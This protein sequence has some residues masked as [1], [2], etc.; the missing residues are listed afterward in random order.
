MTRRW[1][2]LLCG[3][4]TAGAGEMPPK[5]SNYHEALKKR[6][7]SATLFERFREAW[8]E[9]MPAEELEKE[10]LSRAEAGEAGAW[11]VLG[12]ARLAAANE[13]GALEAFGKARAAAP[14]AWLSLEIGRLKLAA[15]D[16]EGAEKEALAVPA[17]DKL[18]PDALKLAGLACLRGGRIEE[19]Q[20]HWEQAVAAAPGDKSLLEDLTELTRREGRLDLALEYGGKWRE[21]A[22]DAYARALATLVLAELLEASQRHDDALTELGA[23]LEVS[24]DGSWLE[25]EALSRVERAFRQRGDM[26]R[27]AAW[28]GE[29]ADANP[30][31]LNFRRAQAQALSESGKTAEA[32][33]VLAT[34]LKRL[35]GDRDARWQRIG[36]LER[37]LKLEQAYDECA[38][39]AAEEKSEE[40]GLRRAELAFRLGRE[41]EVKRALDEVLSSA[42]PAKRPALAGLYARYGMPEESEK[43]WRAA[44]KGEHGG[45]ALRE[46]AKFLRA[47][48][49]DKE[50]IAVWREIG[51]RDSA[52]D[53]MEAARMLA[54]AGE[55]KAARELL[56]SG[57]E[58]H[59][60]HPGYEAARAELALLED[61]KDEALEIYRELA[62]KAERPDELAAALRGWLSA[63]EGREEKLLAA[64]GDSPGERCLRMAWLAREGKPLPE[65]E[66]ELERAVRLALLKENRRW[67]E[68]VAMMEASPAGGPLHFRE[69]AEA[70]EAAGD[71]EGALAAVRAWRE[72]SPDQAGAWVKEANLLE[73]A[74]DRA[75]AERLLRR[76]VARFEEDPD[77]PRRLFSLLE[78][79]GEIGTALDFA[80]QRHDRA[81]EDSARA[82]WLREII[83]VARE[84][85]RLE[86]LK[87]RFEERARRDPASPGPQRA[88]AEL[89]KARGDSR[90]EM[91]HL[92][93][94]ADA[95]PSD[96]ELVSALAAIEERNGQMERA[97]ER[98]RT[99]AKLVPGADSAMKL[100]Q[101]KIRCGDIEGG[102]R[103]LQ[104]LA[105][106]EG[107]DLRELEKSAGSLATGGHM[108]E[109][110]RLLDALDPARFDARLHFVRGVILEAAGRPQ[111][112][113][114]DYLKVMAEPE[115]PAESRQGGRYGSGFGTLLGWLRQTDSDPQQVPGFIRYF[116]V[117][118]SLAE[119]KMLLGP[120]VLRLAMEL[121]D[122]AWD[123]TCR[124]MTELESVT[125]AQW[126]LVQE[127]AAQR[128][129]GY[130]VRWWQFALEH[131]EHPL[132]TKLMRSTG[133][134]QGMSPKQAADLLESGREFPVE[135]QVALRL[136][137]PG[138]AEELAE[139]LRGIDPGVWKD[140]M[141]ASQAMQLLYRV[142]SPVA[143]PGQEG[144]GKAPAGWVACLEALEG[145]EF[146]GGHL[147]SL[148]SF[149]AVRDLEKGD[150]DGFLKRIEEAAEASRELADDE[151]QFGISFA[152]SGPVTSAFAARAEK[153]REALIARMST[154]VLR[155]RFGMAG[156][157]DRG[158][159]RIRRELAELPADAVEVRR[160]LIR[161]SWMVLKDP[162]ERLK[163]MKA[164]SADEADPRLA[165]D[166]LMQLVQNEEEMSPETT[167][168]MKHLLG[169]LKAG[170]E[171]ERRYA[172]RYDGYFGMSSPA[173]ATAPAPGRWGPPWQHQPSYRSGGNSQQR[174]KGLLEMKDRP[175]AVR[176]AA[177]LLEESVLEEIRGMG[178][179]GSAVTLLKNAGLLDEALSQIRVPEN[180]GLGRRVAALKL[181]DAGRRKEEAREVV[182]ELSR[183]WPRELRWTIELAMRL[184]DRAE[185]FALLGRAAED[186]D[187]A[188]TLLGVVLPRNQVDALS[189][190]GLELLA[191]WAEGPGRERDGR[192]IGEIAVLFGRGTPVWMA[193]PKEGAAEK[194]PDFRKLRELFERYR[195]LGLARPESAEIVFRVVHA[196]R[197]FREPEAVDE[198]AREVLLCGAY[199]QG[200]AALI[201]T[202]GVARRVQLP[203]APS[204]LEHLVGIAV[205]KGDAVAF[206]AGFREALAK[207][208]PE[209]EAWLERLLAAKSAPD[210]PGVTDAAAMQAGGSWVA[211]A[212][213]E[214]A[215]LR[216]GRMKGREIL[217][218]KLFRG[219]LFGAVSRNADGVLAASLSEALKQGSLES[220]IRL[221]LEAAEDPRKGARDA[222]IQRMD[223]FQTAGQGILDAVA[224]RRDSRLLVEVLK[225][226]G[227]WK[228]PV[229]SYNLEEALGSAWLG[230]RSKGRVAALTDLP[231][232]KT[233]DALKLGTWQRGFED[234][235]IRDSYQWFG[236]RAMRRISQDM[237]GNATTKLS[238]EILAKPDASFMELLLV[239][240]WASDQRKDLIKRAL[241]KA[242][243][244]LARLP[245]EMRDGVVRALTQEF[246]AGDLAGLPKPVADSL[247]KFLD[248]AKAV[249]IQAALRFKEE[250]PKPGESRAG[251]SR[252]TGHTLGR[253]ASDDPG[254][255]AGI[256]EA[257]AAAG[258]PKKGGRIAVAE[259]MELTTGMLESSSGGAAKV[260]GMLAILEEVWKD[261]PLSMP[262]PNA[263]YQVWQNLGGR[264][265]AEPSTWQGI[266]KLSKPM[267]VRV[268][269]SAS[270]AF[271]RRAPVDAKQRAAL[272]AAAKGSELTRLACAWCL[273][274]NPADP[275]DFRSG[276]GKLLV[277][278]LEAMKRADAG[279][280]DLL[281][282]V[283]DAYENLGRL[284]DPLVLLAATP[285]LLA[286]VKTIPPGE[287]ARFF[288]ALARTGMPVPGARTGEKGYP[289]EAGGVLGLLL[290][291]GSLAKME[292][293]HRSQLSKLVLAMEDPDLTARWIRAA[294][295]T[296][297][298]DLDFTLGLLKQGQPEQAL[299]LVPPAGKLWSRMD[300]SFTRETEQMV[301]SLA[302]FDTT[303]TFRLRVHLSLNRDAYGEEA[304][305]ETFEFRRARLTEEFGKRANTMSPEE[306]MSLCALLGIP[307]RA[308]AEPVALLDEFL[309]EDPEA[310]FRRL[311]SDESESADRSGGIL[312]RLGAA[313]SAFHRGDPRGVDAFAAALG[314]Q[315]AMRPDSFIR[316]SLHYSWLP[317]LESTFW[318]HADRHDGVMP[319]ETAKAV[320]R[321]A[322]V[323]GKIDEGRKAGV[324]WTMVLLASP[325]AAALERNLKQ[326]GLPVR[327]PGASPGAMPLAA[328]PTDFEESVRERIGR[329]KLRMSV[330][331][332]A[333][334]PEFVA[335]F[336]MPRQLMGKPGRELELLAEEKLRA[337]LPP[338]RFLDWLRAV[339]SLTPE[340]MELAKTYA[341]ERRADFNEIQWKA[342]EE[343]LAMPELPV[344]V[345]PDRERRPAGPGFDPRGR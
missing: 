202:S 154:P 236:L 329:A 212:R 280:A 13:E 174:L 175:Q 129:D 44:A 110:I 249:R 314:P 75:G 84:N 318:I 198:A 46:L 91:E 194:S 195:K 164:R 211:R 74:G 228:Q 257:W 66:G 223:S 291:R 160:E 204:A 248:K 151:W 117:P 82:G 220:R 192:W 127:F 251:L 131:P 56:E 321:L 59:A 227:G 23:V 275:K 24:G 324:A 155:C 306:R 317:L 319:E 288:S 69:L 222:E 158:L 62:V 100:A 16:F 281:A 284:A 322:A 199:A 178:S 330:L 95:A 215:M 79:K 30:T 119:S 341:N 70:K 172:T 188:G 286:E 250:M 266:A 108:D 132:A 32:L 320:L 104:M 42:D 263:F 140:S 221:F 34:V 171:A 118:G 180:A 63:A 78:G 238:Q 242:A 176:E 76:A 243:P 116:T 29:V 206:P 216:A 121:G 122:E 184:E 219:N 157:E 294:G 107:L 193:T 260:F 135:L 146:K 278:W 308:A 161:L 239:S 255:A 12:R 103:D 340:M 203:V 166:A 300:G 114:D 10:L 208:D 57:R 245:V 88:L 93:K 331:H 2:L 303:E 106:D 41:D 128:G 189:Q 247:R 210:L 53:R 15:K 230:D 147:A 113:L 282:L 177:A 167:R 77:A 173:T 86:E 4:V 259:R 297:K 45:Q 125:P 262:G 65:V 196:T 115:D 130:S 310:A 159:A 38:A 302:G 142:A 295:D 90:A 11:A 48:K 136:I 209:T 307:V 244:E 185:A 287:T 190:P 5:A 47:E 36:L 37:D 39:L 201:P 170:G 274:L 31:R 285:G 126:R 165:L 133:G 344:P 21:A 101:A 71:A 258:V 290:E 267:Q 153:D 218:E 270:D 207:A 87:A 283:M 279:E 179:M 54:G 141:L 72:R 334:T 182:V 332:P 253:I 52:A 7:E 316:N 8:L 181:F 233:A 336:A 186:P 168:R 235:K 231:G 214:A 342:W 229:Q 60:A 124:V 89:A 81:E 237:Q 25:R 246:D 9:E 298:G 40:T 313:C 3:M 271:S 20:G 96:V 64:L 111:D 293:Y 326:A 98:H 276:D 273:S 191:D 22:E 339:R 35:P 277:A 224:R 109:A 225:V 55:R 240:S 17:D 217:L 312:V 148:R 58:K 14:A 112:A 327:A 296:L 337:A 226:L 268:L 197:Q 264:A 254:L 51:A 299:A 169:R 49:R 19:A 102:M 50:A 43:Q 333:A 213:H 6:P 156:D 18:R 272:V 309:G 162:A 335:A 97:L 123:R 85:D 73:A 292:S 120:K 83:R 105:G 150:Q 200:R 61:R 138:T 144:P 183:R 241:K 68:A 134:L 149:Q 67:A 145:A 256:I 328:V 139:W 94:A 345:R 261:E 187:F 137:A 27:R 1:C 325:D 234:G 343:R 28:L 305:A 252:Q 338:V 311:I 301:A 289:K 152:T 304:P 269:S 26:T 80:W 323:L 265:I 143:V 205:E 163:E 315:V 92:R 99:L 33:E 232:W